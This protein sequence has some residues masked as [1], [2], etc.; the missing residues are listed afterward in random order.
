MSTYIL[1]S[2][3]LRDIPDHTWNTHGWVKI[4]VKYLCFPFFQN[5]N[6]SISVFSFFCRKNTCSHILIVFQLHVN[7]SSKKNTCNTQK[8]Q[9][10]FHVEKFELKKWYLLIYSISNDNFWSKVKFLEESIICDQNED[11]GFRKLSTWSWV[12]GNLP[13]PFF[14]QI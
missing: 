11:E 2:K 13:S 14:L 8:M 3:Y 5:K 1:T 12:Q 4:Q 9:R 10:K 7:K 6:T